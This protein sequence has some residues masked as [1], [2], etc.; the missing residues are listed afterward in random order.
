M[1]IEPYLIRLEYRVFGVF[2]RQAKVYYGG[3]FV[4]CIFKSGEQWH[5]PDQIS[6]NRWRDPIFPA[7]LLVR[8]WMKRKGE[9]G[10]VLV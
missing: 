8:K 4:G 7:D 5:L 3:E 9:S 2:L 6:N 1:K 10:H